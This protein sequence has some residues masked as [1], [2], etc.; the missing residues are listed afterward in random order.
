MFLRPPV[1]YWGLW[2]YGSA[3]PQQVTAVHGDVRQALAH[4]LGGLNGAGHGGVVD[5]G[6]AFP[7]LFQPLTWGWGSIAGR[8]TSLMIP[9]SNLCIQVLAVYHSAFY[10]DRVKI[11]TP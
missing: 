2:D 6:V 7:Q 11:E 1:V 10:N 3:F 4:Q 5:G 8:D 9:W